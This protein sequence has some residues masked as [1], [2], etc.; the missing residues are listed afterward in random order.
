MEHRPF[1]S[2]IS[3]T[4]HVDLMT[5]QE[6]A[7]TPED[8]LS[9][10]SCLEAQLRAPVAFPQGWSVTRELKAETDPFLHELLLVMV[11]IPA[12]ETIR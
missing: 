5:L 10:E 7:Y 1:P 11:F 8:R 6:E 12:V 9:A 4:L 2:V 3:L